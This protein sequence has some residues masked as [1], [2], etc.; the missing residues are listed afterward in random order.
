MPMRTPSATRALSS[1]RVRAAR[2]AFTLVE[3][4]VAIAIMVVLTTLVL[5]AFQRDDGDR[6]SASARRVQAYLEGARSRAIADK[7]PTG[8]RLIR[9]STD[10]FLIDSLA[11]IGAV[12]YLEGTV[13]ITYLGGNWYVT[14]N[15][16]GEWGRLAPP[17]VPLAPG[18]S[19]V[20]WILNPN[21]RNLLRTGA[22]IELP[23]G[24]GN[25]YTVR[26]SE[27]LNL[28]GGL[29]S[30]EDIDGDMALDYHPDVLA[31]NS[32]YVPST[33]NGTT[34][35]AQPATAVPYR[36]E[37]AATNLPNSESVMLERGIVIDLH[38]SQF[39][40]FDIM[41]DERGVPAGALAAQGLVHLYITTL[42]DV[43]LTRSRFPDHPANFTA[44]AMPTPIVPADAPSVPRLPPKLVTV[45]AQTG[46]I[47]TSDVDLTDVQDYIMSGPPYMGPPAVGADLWADHPFRFARR[48]KE[49]K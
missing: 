28:N 43:E 19:G 11:Y 4:L 35:I 17:S 9:S 25:W 5:A 10:P 13:D 47:A 12:E 23:A 29:E 48:G 2:R 22:R 44:T 18:A 1:G 31:L 46:Q 45:Y 16:P 14:N 38:A 3:L 30:V 21:G 15:V 24:T 8:V 41:F 7:R 40:S 6:L 32:H 39:G 49:A 33:W 34:Y 20:P 37:M 36:L 26:F 27:D 42:A